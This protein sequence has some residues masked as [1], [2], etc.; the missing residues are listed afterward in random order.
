MGDHGGGGRG[1][2]NLRTARQTRPGKGRGSEA[3]IEEDCTGVE[4][5]EKA[6]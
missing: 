4:Q 3:G 5:R 1:S 6:G 2:I